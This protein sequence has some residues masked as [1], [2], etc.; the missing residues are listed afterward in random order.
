VRGNFY[1]VG[2]IQYG[3]VG[4]NPDENGKWLTSWLP[5]IELRNKTITKNGKKAPGNIDLSC[6]GLDPYDNNTTVDGRRSDAASYVFRK[7]DPMNPYQTGT[8]VCEYVN[9]PKVAEI[10]YEDMVMQSVF[11]GHEILI[12]SNK[13]GCINYFLSKG[14]DN[15]LMRRP[16][17]TQTQSSRKMIE[18]YG[19]PMSGVESR[20]SLV[21]ATETFI[22]NKVGFIQ[23]EGKEPYM[24][25]CPFDK[26]LQTWAEYDVDDD[27]TKYDC[28]VGAGL[29]LL[30]ARKYI[31]KVQKVKRMELFPMYR[32]NGGQSERIR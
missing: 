5:P 13:I 12:E 29:A 17:E 9:R 32:M 25:N 1:W 26:L 6:A 8:F 3:S 14:Y 20:Q 27:W 24:G 7:F 10:M 28:M 22:I 4:W 21:Y 15:Y 18:D 2:G 19:I 11:Y 16:E 30:G 31:P 23:E